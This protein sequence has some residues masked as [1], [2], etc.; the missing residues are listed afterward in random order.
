MPTFVIHAHDDRP[1]ASESSYL[2]LWRD[3]RSVG[4]LE[5]VPSVPAPSGTRASGI[6]DVGTAVLTVAPTATAVVALVKVVLDWETRS[7]SRSLQIEMPDG[8]R[9]VIKADGFPRQRVSEL[10]DQ[11]ISRFAREPDDSSNGGDAR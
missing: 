1:T 9:M 2:G 8:T 11:M 4:R 6:V 3:L 7:R 10:A 5:P